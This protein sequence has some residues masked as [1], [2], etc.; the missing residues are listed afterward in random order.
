MKNKKQISQY[1]HK[2]YSEM[3]PLLRD[4]TELIELGH[5]HQSLISQGLIGFNSMKE[6]DA[7][8]KR[9]QDIRNKILSIQRL[10][11]TR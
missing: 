6:A 1:F 10:Y 9:I 4:V 8:L 2:K 3:N 5:E 11:L 7:A